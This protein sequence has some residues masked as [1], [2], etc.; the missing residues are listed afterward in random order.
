MITLF[1]GGKS[2]EKLCV[3]STSGMGQSAAGALRTITVDNQRL[4]TA[5]LC[6][7]R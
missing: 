5:A 2:A 3:I 7:S 4:V 1:L 6:R